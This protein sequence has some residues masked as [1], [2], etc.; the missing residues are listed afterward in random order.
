MQIIDSQDKKERYFKIN[1]R[2]ILSKN[3]HENIDYLSKYL[4]NY[5]NLSF[6]FYFL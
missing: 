3:T 1:R 6:T 5:I 2:N 4:P